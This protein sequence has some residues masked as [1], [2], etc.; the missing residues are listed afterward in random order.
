M[1]VGTKKK[2]KVER[3]IYNWYKMMMNLRLGKQDNRKQ[4]KREMKSLVSSY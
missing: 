1:C 2:K 3:A 4:S